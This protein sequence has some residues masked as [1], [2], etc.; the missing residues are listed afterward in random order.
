M[1][2]LTKNIRHGTVYRKGKNEYTDTFDDLWISGIG[3]G[4]TD[5]L[6]IYVRGTSIDLT[7]SL[8]G[9]K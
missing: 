8:Y 9:R 3:Y 6:T 4:V 5:P 1:I 7:I 2:G